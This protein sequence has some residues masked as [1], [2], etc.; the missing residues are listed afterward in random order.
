VEVH[1]ALAAAW[2]EV[3][4]ASLPEY[5]HEVAFTQ[6]LTLLTNGHGPPRSPDTGQTRDPAPKDENGRKDSA[7]GSPSGTDLLDKFAHEADIP[8][9]ALEEIMYFEGDVPQLT[10]PARKLGKRKA[11]QM[12]RVAIILTGA[13]HY[14]LDQT[15]VPGKTIRSECDRLKVL[16]RPNFGK[17]MGKISSLVVTGPPRSRD[18]KL[19]SGTPG[20]SA[21]KD[22]VN[23]IRGGQADA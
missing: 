7:E 23:E 13:Y 16:D 3:E 10:G 11:D 9:D 2:A 17:V 19:K 15:N 4:K 5:L 12:R 21:L 1:K 20:A 8:R 22:T 18:F 14:A 6:A